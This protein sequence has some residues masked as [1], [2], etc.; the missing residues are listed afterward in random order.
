VV[1]FC[2]LIAI[3]G[4]LAYGEIDERHIKVDL[5]VNKLPLKIRAFF[6]GLAAFLGLVLFVILTW[7]S[8]QYGLSLKAINDV[9]ATSR[10]PLYPF[11][12]WLGISFVPL[13]LVLLGEILKAVLEGSKK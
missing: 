9:T 10:I 11:A 8:F 3:S 4:A 6:H 2:Q 13:C 5:F 7:K 12:F 1:F